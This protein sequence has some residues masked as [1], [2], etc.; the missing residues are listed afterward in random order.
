VDQPRARAAVQG[1]VSP[2]QQPRGGETP[3]RRP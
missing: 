1:L 3:T 2:S